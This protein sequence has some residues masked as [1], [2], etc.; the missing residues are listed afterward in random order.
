MPNDRDGV[1]V[2][3]RGVDQPQAIPLAALD[4]DLGILASWAGRVNVSSIEENVVAGGRG[5]GVARPEGVDGVH[6]A[7]NDMLGRVV[8]PVVDGEDAKVGVVWVC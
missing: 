8:V 7:L 2:I 1:R 6:H 5:A 4:F 3:G